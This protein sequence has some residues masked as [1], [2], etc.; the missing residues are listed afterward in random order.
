MSDTTRKSMRRYQLAGFAGIFVI[1]G[2]VVAWAAFT[3]IRGAVIAPG[4]MVVDG[5][6]K[7]VQ[8]RDGG[9]VATINVRD[10][11]MVKV[12]ARTG[13]LSTSAD[14]SAR[15]PA[16]DPH[17]EWGVGRELFR[18]MQDHADSAEKGAS[19]MLASAGL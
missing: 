19:A 13:E 9:I 4:T 2:S 12:C 16:A 15:E 18:M 17:V 11:D 8:H 3:E 1:M 5:N 6:T 14:L 10:G 7:R